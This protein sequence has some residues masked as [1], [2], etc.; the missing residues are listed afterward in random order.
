MKKYLLHVFGGGFISGSRT[1]KPEQAYRLTP[2]G[3]D[4]FAQLTDD[5]NT[6]I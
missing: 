5:T 3:L 2:K 6:H 1:N 4:L